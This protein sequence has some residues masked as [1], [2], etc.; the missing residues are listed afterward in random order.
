[1]AAPDAVG[2]KNSTLVEALAITPLSFAMALICEA[3]NSAE[4]PAATLRS[5]EFP[6]ATRFKV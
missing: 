4:L 5:V 2:V 3:T 1:M 6:A